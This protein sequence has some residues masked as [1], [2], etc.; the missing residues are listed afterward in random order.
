MTERGTGPDRTSQT[1]AHKYQ[2][3]GPDTCTTQTPK[4]QIEGGGD[5]RERKRKIQLR[6]KKR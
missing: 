4:E 5:E 2:T 3:H 6:E 1:S